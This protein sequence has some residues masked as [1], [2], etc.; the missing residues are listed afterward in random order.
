M[1]DSLHQHR[2]THL[3]NQTSV[4]LDDLLLETRR[5]E[6]QLIP[7]EI[8]DEIAITIGELTLILSDH[9]AVQHTQVLAHKMISQAEE[10]RRA[11]RSGVLSKEQLAQAIETLTEHLHRMIVQ[12]QRA[13]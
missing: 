1:H 11:L 12:D 7:L 10:L 3:L 6:P 5:F 13:A 4:R 8:L 9:L 2:F